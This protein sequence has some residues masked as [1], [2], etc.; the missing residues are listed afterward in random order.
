MNAVV[1]KLG[2]ARGSTRGSMYDTQRTR[3]AIAALLLL[4]AL[5]YV[6]PLGM[7]PLHSPDEVRYGAISHE[8]IESG[9]WVSPRFNGVRYFEK[10]VLGYWL[11]SASLAVFGENAFALRLPAALAT[12]LTALI[13]FAFAH[14]FASPSIAGL[15]TA[16]YLTTFSVAGA[17][18]YASLDAFFAL[19][20]TGTLASYYCALR[21]PH[22]RR[23]YGYLALCGAACAAAF[24]VK[25][26]LAF[27]IAVIVAATFLVARR[28]WCTLFGSPWVPLAVAVVLVLPWAVMIHLRESD[29]WRYFFWV[30]HIQRFMG[31]D[32]QHAQPFWFYFA[33]LPLGAWPWL[34]LLPAA[35]SG[36]RLPGR[37]DR[38]FLWYLATWAIAPLVFL[39]LSRGKLP[40]YLLPC[41]AP[42]AIL[43]ATGLQTYLGHISHTCAGGG[44]AFRLGA[45]AVAGV[46]IAIV[47]AVA[48]AQAGAFGDAPYAPDETGKLA[49]F[50]ACMAA[51]AAC[52]ISAGFAR[53]PVAK[54]AAIAGTGATLLLPLHV[55]LPQRL[56][57]HS[58]L[59]TAVARHAAGPDAAIGPHTALVSDGSLFG[60]LAWQLKR[61]DIHVLDPGEI[62]YGLSWPESRHRWLDRAGLEHL[63]ETHH[64][65]GG[66]L[67]V[68]KH[69]CASHVEKTW[70]PP[71][72]RR[73][74]HGL[75]V[76]W[77]IQ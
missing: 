51:G 19:F 49:A 55:A 16:I 39:S 59:A 43:L 34:L 17:G 56:L 57:E 74:Q 68:C 28:R 23:R 54:L 52:A 71:T 10:P 13:V 63:I 58:T 8:M 77:R 27:A 4:F 14:R 30:E 40:P 45:S 67:I 42:L 24:L 25:G 37:H 46:F 72:A 2:P 75:V 36:L 48:A 73:S 38:D 62:K 31:E 3:C 50:A 41:F 33:W 15:A 11:Y 5:L 21:E 7:R 53:A 47:A 32:A 6:L 69:K 20:L 22:S 29:F 9:D 35:L 64:G 44:R 1:D 61:D 12:A 76:F 60:T 66:I 70:L 65:R 18:T 26:F